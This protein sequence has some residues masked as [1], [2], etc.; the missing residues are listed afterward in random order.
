LKSYKFYPNIIVQGLEYS[1]SSF[2]ISDGAFGS[3]FFFGTGFHG[4]SCSPNNK[5]YNIQKNNKNYSTLVSNTNINNK[6][7]IS[8][9]RYASEVD[10]YYLDR[11]F[12]E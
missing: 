8:V 1:V 4:L 7:N 6:L 5:L 11:K 12:L 2:T 3:C 10:S 9:Q